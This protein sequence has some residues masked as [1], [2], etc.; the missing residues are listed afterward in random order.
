MLICKI[1]HE[2]NS[3]RLAEQ[4]PVLLLTALLHMCTTL[5]MAQ[6]R[7][8]GCCYWHASCRLCTPPKRPPMLHLHGQGSP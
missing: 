8:A 1:Q 5:C 6:P 3:L 7:S 4:A 2:Q